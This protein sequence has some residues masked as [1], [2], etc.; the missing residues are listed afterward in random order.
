MSSS[1]AD[2]LVSA[3]RQLEPVSD[4]ARLDAEILLAHALEKDR[5]YLYTWPAKELTPQL[6]QQFHTLLQRRLSGEPV[7]H[8]TGLREFWSLPLQISEHTLIPRPETELLVDKAL[9]KMPANSDMSVLDLGTGSGAIALALAS[10]RPQARITAIEKSEQALEVALANADH[11]RLAHIRFLQGDWFEPVQGEQFQLILSNPPY[12]AE[13]D[14]H[15]DN[16]D[17]R[18]E[19]GAALIAGQDGLGDL[20]H[21][22]EQAPPF[23]LSPGYLLVEHGYDQAE[24]VRNKMKKHGFIDIRTYRDLY[25]QERVTEGAWR[26]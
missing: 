9:Q 7:A 6:E 26:Q 19:P 17:V 12:I 25:G 21:I 11:L 24:S 2:L 18:F 23:L 13:R 10:E 14:P 8:I 15:L 20:Y 1:I 5:S 4:S 3:T 22:I 16:G